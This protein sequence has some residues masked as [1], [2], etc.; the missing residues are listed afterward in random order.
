MMN[1]IAL[2]MQ[3]AKSIE[4]VETPRLGSVVVKLDM[5]RIAELHLSIDAN[6]VRESVLQTP[7][8]KPKQLVMFLL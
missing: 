1:G 6:T 4:I 5:D 2:V 8:I 3:V 7:K